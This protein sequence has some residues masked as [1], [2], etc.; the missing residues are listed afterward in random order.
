[1]L[2]ARVKKIK[3]GE[4]SGLERDDNRKMVRSQCLPVVVESIDE[5]PCVARVHSVV[6][7]HLDEPIV[8]RP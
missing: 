5:N 6:V 7:E 1:M 3:M 4:L 2:A 8:E